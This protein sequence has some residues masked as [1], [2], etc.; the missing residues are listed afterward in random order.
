MRRKVRIVPSFIPVKLLNET[1]ERKEARRRWRA[2]S[3]ILFGGWLQRRTA[4]GL[5]PTPLS[6]NLTAIMTHLHFWAWTGN[7]GTGTQ[8]TQAPLDEANHSTPPAG[9]YGILTAASK[10]QHT[11]RTG[12]R[13]KRASSDTFCGTSRRASFQDIMHGSSVFGS[14]VQLVRFHHS[15]IVILDDLGGYLFYPI[16]LRVFWIMDLAFL[17]LFPHQLGLAPTLSLPA[18]DGSK[19]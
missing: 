18:H 16:F 1:K 12:S 17:I 14:L 7:T 11:K 9:G 15:I 10:P 4:H 13:N 5:R 3:W 8:G 19:P 2:A 6:T